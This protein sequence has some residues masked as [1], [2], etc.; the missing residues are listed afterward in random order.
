MKN[1]Q[2]TLEQAKFTIVSS[3]FVFSCLLLVI[4]GA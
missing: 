1:I 4:F 3:I 2:L